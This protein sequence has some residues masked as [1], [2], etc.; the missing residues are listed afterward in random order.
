M[1]TVLLVDQQRNTVELELDSGLYRMLGIKQENIKKHDKRTE[2]NNT[3]T[4]F[5]NK[6]YNKD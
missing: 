1:I 5:L 4:A 2:L 3:V 6:K